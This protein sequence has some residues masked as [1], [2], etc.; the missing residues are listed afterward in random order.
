ML[1]WQKICGSLSSH[2]SL[3]NQPFQLACQTGSAVVWPIFLALCCLYHLLVLQI[4]HSICRVVLEV[5]VSH[6][7]FLK[8]WVLIPLFS[9]FPLFNERQF[10]AVIRMPCI[11][12][13]LSVQ[14]IITGRMLDVQANVQIG[15]LN[16]LTVRR[17]I[18][19]FRAAL[20]LFHWTPC[21]R[22]FLVWLHNICL[23]IANLSNIP[24]FVL[25]SITSKPMLTHW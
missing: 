4:V 12:K 10:I 2:K 22:Q 3:S 6:L 16:I 23:K 14:C 15:L 5:H 9:V 17:W 24:Q 19:R 18:W 7:W 25:L 8:C 21:Y 13:E 11:F 20:R 1:L